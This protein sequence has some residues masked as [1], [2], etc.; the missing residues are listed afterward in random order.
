MAKF[1]TLSKSFMVAGIIGFLVSVIFIWKYSK[2]WGFTLG[3][4]FA[5]IFIAS[6]ISMSNTAVG[7]PD[8]YDEL[9]IHEKRKRPKQ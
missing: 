5:F 1:I 3:I 6:L 2:D 4:F 9:A 8:G 7:D